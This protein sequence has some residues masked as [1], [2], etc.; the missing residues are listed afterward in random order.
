MWYQFGVHGSAPDI[1]GKGLANPIACILSF[2]M[3][4]K[5]TFDLKK[6]AELLDKS[7]ERVLSKGIRTADLLQKENQKPSSTIEVCDEILNELNM[8]L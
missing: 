8:Q 5:Y 4:L 3:A 2:S 1:C 6:E 7:V